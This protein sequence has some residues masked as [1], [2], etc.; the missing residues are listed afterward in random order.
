[1]LSRLT[2]RFFSSS[3]NQLDYHEFRLFVL[4]CIDDTKSKATNRGDFL[5]ND[6]NNGGWLS[7]CVA[8]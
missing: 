1:M 4:A 2:L 8:M 6:G 3:L 5:D 7:M